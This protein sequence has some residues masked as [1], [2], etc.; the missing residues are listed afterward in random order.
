MPLPWDCTVQGVP[1]SLQ[2]SARKRTEWRQRV[3]ASAARRWPVHEPPMDQPLRLVVAFLHSGQAVDVD[4]MLKPTLDGLVGVAYA[5]DALL[6]QVTGVRWDLSR[7]LRLDGMSPVLLRALV[8][9]TS[10]GGP[11]VYL[12]LL[13][14]ADFEELVS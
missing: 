12:R 4:N 14:P 8:Q 13:P 11:F 3:G 6:E 10:G 1:A 7:G 5:D 2:G 9:A